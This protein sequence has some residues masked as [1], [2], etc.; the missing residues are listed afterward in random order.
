M[1]RLSIA[2]A[3]KL[4][5]GELQAKPEAIAQIVRDALAGVRQARRVTITVHPSQIAVLQS[6]LQSLELSAACEV[7]IAGRQDLDPAGCLVDSDFGVVDARIETRLATI[8]RAMLRP[9]KTK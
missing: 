9:E 5:G 4:L 8:E 7:R 3:R 2:I 6:Q 1:V